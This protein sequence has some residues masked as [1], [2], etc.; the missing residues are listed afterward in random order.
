MWMPPSVAATPAFAQSTESGT[1]RDEAVT[2]DTIGDVEQSAQEGPRDEAELHADRQPRALGI[3]ESPLALELW[4]DRRRGEPETHREKLHEREQR[5][6]KGL[7][8]ET[9]AWWDVGHLAPAYWTTRRQGRDDA[10]DGA[11]RKQHPFVTS[12]ASAR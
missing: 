2:R 12:D 6:L 3:V 5:Q 11:K 9:G 8:L 10:I 4:Q 7:G 1:D